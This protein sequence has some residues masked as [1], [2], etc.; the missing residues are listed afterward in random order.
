M[1]E[2]VGGTGRLASAVL[3]ATRGRKLFELAE[4]LNYSDTEQLLLDVEAAQ[5]YF[6]HFRREALYQS[7]MTDGDEDEE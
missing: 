6:E 4:V 3:A 2:F 5:D 1:Y 7:G